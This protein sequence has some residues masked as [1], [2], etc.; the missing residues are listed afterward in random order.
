MTKDGFVSNLESVEYGH[1]RLDLG[2]TIIVP[3]TN[4][5]IWNCLFLLAVF[6]RIFS[7]ILVAS[8]ELGLT[9][10]QGVVRKIPGCEQNVFV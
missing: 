9:L 1:P 2:S 7:M 5:S 6:S 4:L 10:Y 8:L 3:D